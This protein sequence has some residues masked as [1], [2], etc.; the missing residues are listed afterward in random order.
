M[1]VKVDLEEV[2]KILRK[3]RVIERKKGDE[4]EYLMT[5]KQETIEGYFEMLDVNKWLKFKAFTV[6]QY[7]KAVK[8]E[9]T[10]LN[11]LK[12]LAV[13]GKQY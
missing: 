13:P 12:E 4:T 7:N 9:E 2:I 11:I 6:E 5:A 8:F 1:H 10:V 3:S